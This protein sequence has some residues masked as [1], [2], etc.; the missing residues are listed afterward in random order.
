MKNLYLILLVVFVT[1]SCS[2]KKEKS[3]TVSKLD[4]KTLMAE[5]MQRFSA[6]WNQ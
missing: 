5:S 6:A 1:F 3:E 4:A 2:P